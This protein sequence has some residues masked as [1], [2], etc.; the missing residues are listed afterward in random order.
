MSDARN[1]SGNIRGGGSRVTGGSGRT[2]KHAD[3]GGRKGG[4]IPGTG[5]EVLDQKE[6]ARRNLQ[7]LS[8]SKQLALMARE[9]CFTDH[10]EAEYEELNVPM[11]D[12]ETAMKKLK[13]MVKATDDWYDAGFRERFLYDVFE[14]WK[15]ELKAEFEAAAAKAAASKTA[16]KQ[17][18]SG[19]GGEGDEG[20]ANTVEGVAMSTEELEAMLQDINITGDERKKIKKKLQKRRKQSKK[21]DE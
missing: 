12:A 18:R 21:Q 7:M 17:K 15:K 10:T 1:S 2:Q 19:M 16:A 3:T 14:V 5:S 20:G 8:M 6:L 11:P 4:G 9:S 13:A